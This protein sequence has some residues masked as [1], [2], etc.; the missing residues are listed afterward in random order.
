MHLPNSWYYWG[1]GIGKQHDCGIG[2]QLQMCRQGQVKE[3]T[4]PA[5]P[6]CP[7]LSAQHELLRVSYS[8]SARWLQFVVLFGFILGVLFLLTAMCVFP[9]RG[10]ESL[11]YY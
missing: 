8:C 1:L 2:E 5:N 7:V 6:R 4:T 3:G 10:S 9:I 11:F